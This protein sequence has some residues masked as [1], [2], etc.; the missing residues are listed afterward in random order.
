MFSFSG[1]ASPEGR[2][3]SRLRHEGSPKGRHGRQGTTGT[4]P[5]RKRHPGNYLKLTVKLFSSPV[6][7]NR[8]AA[9]CFQ[10][11]HHCSFN[12]ID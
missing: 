2:Y 5:G 3:R 12:L 11:C 7:L 8:C 6:F 1:S 9:R 10:V 4:R